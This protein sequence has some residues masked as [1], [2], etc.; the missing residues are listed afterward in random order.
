MA[1]SQGKNRRVAW[2][3]N[4]VHPAL[5]QEEFEKGIFDSIRS[6]VSGA[7]KP[8]GVTPVTAPKPEGPAS[9][10]APKPEG[11]ASVTAPKPTGVTP[12]TASTLAGPKPAGPKPAGPR[13]ATAF[14]WLS[15]PKPDKP[16]GGSVPTTDETLPPLNFDHTSYPSRQDDDFQGEKVNNF[17]PAWSPRAD[18]PYDIKV[19]KRRAEAKADRD[20]EEAHR[21]RAVEAQ[22]QAER[23]RENASR[24]AS[25]RPSLEEEAAEKAEKARR[26]A[27]RAVPTP[28]RVTRPVLGDSVERQERLKD[29]GSHKAGLELLQ[30][31]RDEFPGEKPHPSL[32]VKQWAA[33]KLEDEDAKKAI[34]AQHDRLALMHRYSGVDGEIDRNELGSLFGMARKAGMLPDG[35][36]SDSGYEPTTR[37]PTAWQSGTGEIIHHGS[38]SN[39]VGSQVDPARIGSGSDAG[40][41]LY[42]VSG[43]LK[44]PANTYAHQGNG[45]TA[46]GNTYGADTTP[47]LHSYEIPKDMRV[48]RLDQPLVLDDAQLGRVCAY[49]N[50]IASL[51]GRGQTRKDYDGNPVPTFTIPELREK[52]ASSQD[53]RGFKAAKDVLPELAQIALGDFDPFHK[54]SSHVADNLK[55]NIMQVAGFDA[56]RDTQAQD[57]DGKQ[58]GVVHG[59]H[60]AGVHKLIH[61]QSEVAA[62]DT[63]EQESESAGPFLRRPKQ[64]MTPEIQFPETHA[65]MERARLERGDWGGASADDLVEKHLE[66]SFPQLKTEGLQNNPHGTNSVSVHTMDGLS[67]MNTREANP[68][69]GDLEGALYGMSNPADRRIARIAYLFHD[70]GKS[71]DSEDPSAQKAA[72]RAS[73]GA[74]PGEHHQDKSWDL[75]MNHPDKPLEQFGLSDEETGL[76]QKLISKHHAFGDVV[77]AANEARLN[78]DN[79]RAQAAFA[80]AKEQFGEIA[81]NKRTARLLS[82]MW[83][84][85]V[86]GIPA[87][88]KA[89]SRLLGGF[90]EGA[91]FGE[92]RRQLL[93][94]MGVKHD[95]DHHPE[96]WQNDV[97]NASAAVKSFTRRRKGMLMKSGKDRITAQVRKEEERQRK[98]IHKEEQ[99]EMRGVEHEEDHGISAHE[100]KVMKLIAQMGKAIRSPDSP[101]SKPR[102]RAE[103]RM[104]YGM[105][106]QGSRTK[107]GFDSPRYQ[108]ADMATGTK[109]ASLTDVDPFTKSQKEVLDRMDRWKKKTEEKLLE[110]EDKLVD[111]IHSDHTGPGVPKFVGKYTH[112]AKQHEQRLKRVIDK[113]RDDEE[114]EVREEMDAHDS[115]C[116]K[117]GKDPCVCGKVRKS[118]LSN[119]STITRRRP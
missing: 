2:F 12:V 110:E 47:T 32:L 78:P 13:L 107:T 84:A 8:P 87:Y 40:F 103:N 30:E 96:E 52:I 75:L 91:T 114:A 119:V 29:N 41:G 76:V 118:E 49:L 86:Q 16:A 102:S 26:A 82:S 94:E 117:C 39:F 111:R 80:Q 83:Q 79:P 95:E 24:K 62:N 104:D 55:S 3:E 108:P 70:V 19:A 33:S 89:P 27:L 15:F 72:A 23:D 54:K 56:S 14:D 106:G 85:D 7:P 18:T 105:L 112:G 48:A 31:V 6:L 90:G 5:R 88:R 61:L 60:A 25:G 66:A 116:S 21:V 99:A 98:K 57:R 93:A 74:G 69:M 64:G 11:P 68:A 67:A 51:H 10:T 44:R 71:S 115:R 65:L 20:A 63:H 35:A 73:D 77:K 4:S 100:D 101:Y 45:R 109:I 17:K 28:R 36:S 22:Q 1:E 38:P 46:Q 34:M 81:G 58:Q 92:T 50:A 59:I 113:L 53:Q 97:V 9:V 42:G 43:S 37:T